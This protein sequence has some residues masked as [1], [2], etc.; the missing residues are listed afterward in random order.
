M[1]KSEGELGNG[2]GGEG[3]GAGEERERERAGEE[4]EREAGVAVSLTEDG[5]TA[6]EDMT[7]CL[8][9]LG[10]LFLAAFALFVRSLYTHSRRPLTHLKPIKI[11]ESNPKNFQE[12]SEKKRDF[13]HYL[14]PCT[15]R[16]G[17]VAALVCARAL[18]ARHHM[19]AV[20]GAFTNAKGL[21]LEEGGGICLVCHWM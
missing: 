12:N 8:R 20:L 2:E 16:G 14:P 5:R 9:S 4:R 13:S 17:E 3:V 6:E 1:R 18:F 21:H 10:S 11:N 19:R 15:L 7:D